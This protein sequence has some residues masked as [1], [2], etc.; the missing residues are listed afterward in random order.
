MNQLLVLP[1]Y[2]N[3]KTLILLYKRFGFQKSFWR[4]QQ[5][6]M[7]WRWQAFSCSEHCWQWFIQWLDHL[8]STSYKDIMIFTGALGSCQPN[9]TILPSESSCLDSWSYTFPT[10][11]LLLPL[12]PWLYFTYTVAFQNFGSNGPCKLTNVDILI[13]SSVG[14]CPF[15]ILNDFYSFTYFGTGLT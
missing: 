4:T 8:C 9:F 6:V 5:F 14:D 11:P 10:S 13:I 7:E 15:E 1:Y 2:R 12:F 3:L